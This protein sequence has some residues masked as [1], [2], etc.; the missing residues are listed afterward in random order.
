MSVVIF[1]ALLVLLLDKKQ[2]SNRVE[3]GRFR[4]LSEEKVEHLVE[5]FGPDCNTLPSIIRKYSQATIFS[6]KISDRIQD[7]LQQPLVFGDIRIDEDEAAAL[8]LD[9]KFAVFNSLDEE[10]FEV[11]IESCLTKMKWNRMSAS[12][13][14][15]TKATS[16]TLVC[17]DY[18][19]GGG[20]SVRA[21]DYIPALRSYNF[22]N[23]RST[24]IYIT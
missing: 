10:E 23:R 17:Y 8:L 13:N 16:Q 22:D 19:G 14:F 9:P 20:N 18:N 4:G 15:S 5:K 24:K 7:Q 6:D 12:G 21:I 11:E 1:L 2:R 3:L